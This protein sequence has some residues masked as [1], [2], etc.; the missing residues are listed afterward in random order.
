MCLY[1][2]DCTINH[3]ENEDENEKNKSHRYDINRPRSSHGH[4]Y[5]KYK[6]CLTMIMLIC[7][8]QHLSNEAE[9]MEKLTNAETELKKTLLIKKTCILSG[10]LIDGIP[11]F[12]FPW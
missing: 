2:W 7:I 10:M 11:V 9:L 1:S 5:S 12:L 6:K 4:K 3:N 8:K